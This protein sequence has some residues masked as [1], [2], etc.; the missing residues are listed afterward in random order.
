MHFD[1]LFEPASWQ[2]VTYRILET[3]MLTDEALLGDVKADFSFP[4]RPT[5]ETHL[6]AGPRA[7]KTAGALPITRRQRADD[8]NMRISMTSRFSSARW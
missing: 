1:L 8:V 7:V 6:G 5:I 2:N 4:E 3:R